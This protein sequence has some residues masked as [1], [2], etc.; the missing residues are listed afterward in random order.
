MSEI[1]EAFV[2]MTGVP[3][4]WTNPALMQARNG[5]IQGWEAG[6]SAEREACVMVCDEIAEDKWALYKGRPPYKGNEAGRADP[7][8]QGMSDGA[9]ECGAAIRARGQS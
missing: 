5:F 7:H 2:K 8:Y 3:D 4:A 6:Q 1:K 9:S